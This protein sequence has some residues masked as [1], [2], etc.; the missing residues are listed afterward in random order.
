MSSVTSFPL[1]LCLGL[2]PV[3][4]TNLAGQ[5]KELMQQAC[6]YTFIGRSGFLHVL[7]LMRAV[8][9]CLL[10]IS[11]FEISRLYLKS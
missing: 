10:A 6:S 5:L 11:L 3:F 2:F 8:E 7:I 9:I 4:L 1:N